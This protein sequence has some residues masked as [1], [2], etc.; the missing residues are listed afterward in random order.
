MRE[1]M[2]HQGQVLTR[3]ILLD[4]V[5]GINDYRNERIVDTYI[6]RLRKKFGDGYILTVRGMGYRMVKG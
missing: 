6:K 2:L 1:L 3:R 4:R 5:W